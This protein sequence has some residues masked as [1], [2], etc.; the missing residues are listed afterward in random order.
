[1]ERMINNMP[2]GSTLFLRAVLIIMAVVVLGALIALPPMEGRAVNL[3][4]FEIYTN[5]LIVYGYLSSLCFFFGLYQAYKLLD[6][7]D[8]NKAFSLETIQRLKRI[9]YASVLL[10]VLIVGAVTYIHFVAAA[11]GDDPAGPTM[12]GFII[13]ASLSVVAATAA[14]GQKLVQ[15]ALELKSENDLTV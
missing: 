3:S 10:I 9:K 12:L 7:I 2:K 11:D 14:I 8:Q 15:N 1:M 13:S 4:A 5:P 6:L